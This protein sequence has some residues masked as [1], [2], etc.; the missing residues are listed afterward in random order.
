MTRADVGGGI[1]L[2]QER[3]PMNGQHVNEF[4]GQV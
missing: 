1:P 4:G 3:I 2:G